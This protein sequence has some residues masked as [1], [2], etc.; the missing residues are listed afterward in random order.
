M[1]ELEHE[2]RVVDVHV[3]LEPDESRR[4]D[5]RTGDP[6]T[7][8]R[9][10]HQAGVVRSVVFPGPRDG[11]YLKINNAVARMSVGRSFAAFARINGARDAGSSPG[12]RLRNLASSREDHH[13]S[14]EDVEQY[15][16]DDRFAGFKLHP[17]ADG[18][19]DEEVLERLADVGLP[20]L[21][22][23][24]RQFPPQAIADHLLDYEFPVIVEHFGGY[25]LD[26]ELIEDGI[27]LLDR[28][29]SCYLDTSFVRI[30]NPLE[31]AIMEHPDR[32]CFGSGAPATHPDV[33]V[34]EIL[35]LDVPEDA[36]R[37]VF[38]KNPSRVIPELGPSGGE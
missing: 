20:V 4:P 8:E 11:S 38:S 26:R 22:H 10:M 9:E 29:E 15:A 32:I 24:G 35:T 13:T 34:M 19:P 27:A 30:R 33:G 16:Y 25:P 37:K 3:C 36:M 1:L 31:R 21:V 28:W 17:A 12:A 5:G 14:P 6:E 18:L 23:G 2:F 7:I